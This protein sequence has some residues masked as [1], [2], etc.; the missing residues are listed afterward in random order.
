MTS[1]RHYRLMLAG[2]AC[3][4]AL[5][6]SSLLAPSPTAVVGTW[7]LVAIRTSGG[8]AQPRPAG[9][10]YQ[11]TIDSDRVSMRVDCNTCNGAAT[12]LSSKLTLGPVL[13]CTRAAC[14]TATFESAVTTLLSG[15][16]TVGVNDT[17]LTLT[18]P[19][20]VAQFER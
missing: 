3:L 17:M 20:G 2:A 10:T 5:S 9:V 14:P 16:H 13:A 11:M 4:T 1:M 18:S 15:D 7:N 19:R 12:L 6:C 8:A